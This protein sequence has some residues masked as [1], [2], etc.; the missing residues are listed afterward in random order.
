MGHV[1]PFKRWD[2]KIKLRCAG[3]LNQSAKGKLKIA[4]RMPL[5]YVVNTNP[6][7]NW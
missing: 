2:M 1:P 4:V 3:Y 6:Y 7:S 5:C